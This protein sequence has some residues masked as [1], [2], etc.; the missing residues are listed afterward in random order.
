M[1]YRVTKDQ[2]QEEL[3]DTVIFLL[4]EALDDVLEDDLQERLADAL[5]LLRTFKERAINE[6]K[7][8]KE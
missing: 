8:Y 7:P 3:L 6:F 2:T 5:D 1:I 4:R